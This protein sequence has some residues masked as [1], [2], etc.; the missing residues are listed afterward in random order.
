MDPGG[1]KCKCTVDLDRKTLDQLSKHP[2]TCQFLNHWLGEK[3][4]GMDRYLE[5]RVEDE[6]DKVKDNEK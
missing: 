4:I 2:A 1:G 6:K 3:L 5:K